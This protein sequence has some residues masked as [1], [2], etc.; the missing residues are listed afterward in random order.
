MSRIRCV[1]SFAIRFPTP[2]ATNP[3][4]GHSA[5]TNAK[6]VEPTNTGLLTSARNRAWSSIRG[7]EV[8]LLRTKVCASAIIFSCFVRLLSNIMCCWRA[9][10]CGQESGSAWSEHRGCRCCSESVISW[11]FSC[12]CGIIMF[13]FARVAASLSVA[14]R[15][16]ASRPPT[17][18]RLPSASVLAALDRGRAP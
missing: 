11:L 5:E 4:A 16:S 17:F 15:T 9:P 1:F 12:Q 8:G 18:P 14:S 13:G 6:K 10:P 3:V 2:A 7:G